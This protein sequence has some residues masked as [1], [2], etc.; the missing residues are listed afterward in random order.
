LLQFRRP[1][2]RHGGGLRVWPGSRPGGVSCRS[3]TWSDHRRQRAALSQPATGWIVRCVGATTSRRRLLLLT[4]WLTP[5]PFLP[6]LFSFCPNWPCRF[7]RENQRKT[8]ENL[9]FLPFQRWRP[10]PE[11]NRRQ[12][13]CSPVRSHSAIGP[14][15]WTPRIRGA[16]EAVN[17]G[18]GR[19]GA[20]PALGPRYVVFAVHHLYSCAG[21]R[22]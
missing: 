17:K 18:R 2:R 5:L 6:V 9:G 8:A 21:F 16:A 10:E 3:D 20:G 13:I 14:P 19:G 12:R 4:F 1:G 11:S 22:G 7:R 15:E